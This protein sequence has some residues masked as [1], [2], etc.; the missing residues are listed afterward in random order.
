MG[1]EVTIN[2]LVRRT[3]Q[4]F[5]ESLVSLVCGFANYMRN[6]IIGEV[7]VIIILELWASLWAVAYGALHVPSGN[8]SRY[9]TER[10]IP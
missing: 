6:N 8:T 2:D 9:D 5:G 3:L 4:K 10:H 1:D 7:A